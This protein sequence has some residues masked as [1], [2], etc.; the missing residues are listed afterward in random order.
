MKKKTEGEKSQHLERTFE[1]NSDIAKWIF[2]EC[3][4]HP[5][6]NNLIIPK[7]KYS[8][9]SV[10]QSLLHKSKADYKGITTDESWGLFYISFSKQ[11]KFIPEL[12]G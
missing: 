5:W 3:E 9:I 1:W 2:K 11:G 8:H 12:C 7:I 10:C 6:L 4:T